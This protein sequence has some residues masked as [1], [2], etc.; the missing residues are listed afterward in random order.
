[1]WGPT[2][3]LSLIGSAVLTFIGYKQTSKHPTREAKYFSMLSVKPLQSRSCFWYKLNINLP[4]SQGS[5]E[6]IEFS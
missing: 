5:V 3:N 2:Q 1:M 4:D 6:Y